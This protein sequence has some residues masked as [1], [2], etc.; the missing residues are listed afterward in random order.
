MKKSNLLDIVNELKELNPKEYYNWPASVNYVFGTGI[1]IAVFAAG[2]FFHLIPLKDELDAEYKKEEDLKRQFIEKKNQ[3]INLALYEEQ[4]VNI[5]RDS[6][7]L[8]KQ[9]P[10]RSQIEKLLIDINQAAVSR[11]L[12]VELFKPGAEKINEFYAEMPINVKLIGDYASIGN[13]TADVSMLS[14]V[15]VFKDM[16][17]A[18]DPKISN[19]ILSA[20]LKTFRYLDKEELDEQARLAAE[21]KKK[22]RKKKK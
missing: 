13:F 8:L 10:N 4:L 16:E 22:E 20:T 18:T 11:G 9:L 17:V 12:Q 21:A 3:A 5:T 15:V 1:M 7:E 14:R 6:N 19:V 2:F